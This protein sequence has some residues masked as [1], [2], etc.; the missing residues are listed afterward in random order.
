MHGRASGIAS[1]GL[2]GRSTQAANH[3]VRRSRAMIF[4][5]KPPLPPMPET[6]IPVPAHSVAKQEAVSPHPDYDLH[7]VMVRGLEHYLDQGD[8]DDRFHI[9]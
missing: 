8:P 1:S 7:P 2:A 6:H 4:P 5:V 3:L 9:R